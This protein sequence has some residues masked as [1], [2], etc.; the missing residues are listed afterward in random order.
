MYGNNYP[1][2]EKFGL[3]VLEKVVKMPTSM[4]NGNIPNWLTIMFNCKN[5]IFPT[6]KSHVNKIAFF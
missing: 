3:C 2:T 1:N 6:R 5:F 4:A